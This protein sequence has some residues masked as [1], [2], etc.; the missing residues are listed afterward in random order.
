MIES[1]RYILEFTVFTAVFSS[2]ML[3]FI[4]WQLLELQHAIKKR[5]RE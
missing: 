5:N 4:S 3:V 2:C 1:L